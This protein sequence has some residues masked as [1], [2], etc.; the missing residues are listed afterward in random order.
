MKTGLVMYSGV[1][2]LPSMFEA[3]DWI[4]S[5]TKKTGWMDEWMN[6]GINEWMNEKRNE[7]KTVSCSYFPRKSPSSWWR[8]FTFEGIIYKDTR[9]NSSSLSRWM[10]SLKSYTMSSEPWHGLPFPINGYG[11][12]LFIA[13]GMNGYDIKVVCKFRLKK[14]NE[15]ISIYSYH[16]SLSLSIS[17]SI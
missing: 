3:L 6:E 2:Y 11:F 13:V 12:F 17:L 8:S 9:N 4:P 14:G 15:S 7:R 1:E 10:L 5:T 16:L